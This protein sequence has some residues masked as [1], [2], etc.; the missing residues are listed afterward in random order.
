MLQKSQT[1]RSLMTVY[2]SKV[3]FIIPLFLH[4]LEMGLKD[5][6][7]RAKLPPV[8]SE[9]GASGEELTD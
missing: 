2:H 6:T 3:F 4:A 7:I 9:A 5:E 8:I 1:V